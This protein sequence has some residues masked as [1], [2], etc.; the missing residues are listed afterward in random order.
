MKPDLFENFNFHILENIMYDVVGFLPKMLVFLLY[1]V[2]CWLLL[3]LIVFVLKKLL[4]FTKLDPFVSNLNNEVFKGKGGD[5]AASDV[6]VTIV[7]YFFVV[8]FVLVGAD[9]MGLD[10]LSAELARLLGYLPQFFVGLIIFVLGTY[11][12]IRIKKF[13]IT[14]STAMGFMGARILGQFIFLI[15]MVFTA[16]TSLDQIGIRT[17]FITNNISIIIASFFASIALAFGLGGKE[18]VH[19]ILCM[20]YAR[21][22]FK[23]GDKIIVQEVE[24]T[25]I[26]IDH[27]CITLLLQDNRKVVLP[28][29][30]IIRNKVKIVP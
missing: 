10:N 30:D 29:S 18:I 21:K 7:K 20:F 24:G 28:I 11:L 22:N 5:F 14:I 19:N 15:L 6:V 27:L 9:F 3:K 25:V 26:S 17:D 8:V 12:S 4:K 1:F 23:V 13:I 2:V 16:I